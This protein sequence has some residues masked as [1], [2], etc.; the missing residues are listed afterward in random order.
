MLL[1]G[2]VG[3]AFWITW[4]TR[5]SPGGLEV[6]LHGLWEFALRLTGGGLR[7]CVPLRVFMCVL[8]VS[9]LYIYQEVFEMCAVAY[10]LGSLLQGGSR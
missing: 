3:G 6:T 8:C 9:V 1:G 10:L 2:C 4:R 5:R 7:R